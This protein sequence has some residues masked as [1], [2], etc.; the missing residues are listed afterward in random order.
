[1]KIFISTITVIS[2][3]FSYTLTISNGWNLRGAKSNID[4][5]NTFNNKNIVSIWTYENNQWKAYFPN[6]NEI[7]TSIKEGKIFNVFPLKTIK[8][9]YGFWIL[10]KKIIKLNIKNE[11]NNQTENSND[12]DDYY[13]LSKGILNITVPNQSINIDLS[14]IKTIKCD[15]LKPGDIFQIN[16][17]NYTVVNN[18]SIRSVKDYTHICTSHVI[19]MSNLFKDNETFNQDINKWDTSNVILMNGMFLGASSFNQNLN[20][21]NT[22]KVTNMRSMFNSAISFNSPINKWDTSKVTDMSYM[23][24][25]AM[26]FNQPIG[27]WNISHVTSTWHMFDGANSFNQPIGKW[28]T[29]HVTNMGAMFKNATNFDQPLKDWNTSNVKNSAYA[30]RDMGYMFYGATNFNQDISTWCVK[31]IKTKPKTFDI[32]AG[33]EGVSKLQPKWG[34]C[35]KN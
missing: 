1:M 6:N 9:S 20:D 2:L 18:K 35:P 10:S 33:F 25:K 4:V 29:S 5:N 23:F 8:D 26:S 19:D 32:G 30:D 28:N 34:T 17:K 21:W 22:S 11:Q 14:K 16:D 13:K 7:T 3:S 12:N 27:E 15:K 24:Y 31:N